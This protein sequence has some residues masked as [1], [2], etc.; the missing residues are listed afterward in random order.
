MRHGPT[1]DPSKSFADEYLPISLDTLCPVP[2][3]DFDLYVPIGNPGGVVLYREKNYRLERKDLDQ[4]HQ[5]GIRTLYISSAAQTA[6]RRYLFD[7]AIKNSG[8]PPAQRFQVLTTVTRSAFD[9]AFRCVSPDHL[10]RFAGEFGKYLADIVCDPDFALFDLLTL[11]KHDYQT[12]THSVNV[13]ACATALMQMFGN[14]DAAELRRIASAAMLHDIGK[15]RLPR[16]LL[17]K[18]RLLNEQEKELLC[19]HPKIAFDELC[20]RA[21]QSW[22]ALMIVYQHHERVDGKG[23]PV[24]LVGDEIHPWARACAIGNTFEMLKSDRSLHG[25]MR[26][27]DIAELMDSKA[28]RDFDEEMVRCWTSAI[29]QKS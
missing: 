7:S 4:L 5:T 9:A 21:D 26:L 16:E 1:L 28:G 12:Y 15:R 18:R 17:T 14:E 6:Y 3:L 10:C 24:G 25:M 27:R 20:M 13:S 11:L 22:P 8:V 19:E 23:Y 2:V 29:R